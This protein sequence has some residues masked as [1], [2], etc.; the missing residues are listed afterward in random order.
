MLSRYEVERYSPG[1]GGGV[2]DSRMAVNF[3]ILRYAMKIF[4]NVC[5]CRVQYFS[6]KF[7]ID[8]TKNTFGIY[9]K[10]NLALHSGRYDMIKKKLKPNLF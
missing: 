8:T 2:Q 5:I 4:Y 1:K 7:P 3:L 10:N 9:D 6:R